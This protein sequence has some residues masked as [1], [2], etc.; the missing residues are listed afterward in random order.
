MHGSFMALDSQQCCMG[1]PCVDIQFHI[2]GIAHFSAYDRYIFRLCFMG[3]RIAPIRHTVGR[4]GCIYFGIRYPHVVSPKEQAAGSY[5]IEKKKPSV[6]GTS[7]QRKHLGLFFM[8]VKIGST[9]VI[10]LKG[11]FRQLLNLK[12]GHVA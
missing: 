4:F 2:F 5:S 12:S 6:T 7:L 11:Y 9:K 3:A 8:A 10:H 1:N